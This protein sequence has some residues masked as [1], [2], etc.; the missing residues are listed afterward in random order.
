MEKLFISI[1]NRTLLLGCV[2]L[3]ASAVTIAIVAGV[4]FLNGRNPDI[5]KGYVNVAYV[6]L[7]PLTPGEA[8][9]GTAEDLTDRPSQEDI[10]LRAQATPG[11]QALGRVATTITNKRLDIRGS[12][13]TACEKTLAETAKE[14]D[15]KAAN[16]LSE[17]AGYFNQLANDPHLATRYPDAGG[18][19]QARQILEGLSRDFESKFQAQVNAQDA[20]NTAA[21]AE[22][23]EERLA[24]MTFLT[25]A[26]IAFLGFLCIAFL[27]VFL[28]I[29]KH[30]EK[31]SENGMPHGA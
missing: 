11:C 1:L 28:R 3:L 12:G 17:A 9:P 8:A 5:D 29:E 25:V 24:G 27:I 7:T 30:L 21:I 6:P 20:K 18:D 4:N 15:A 2:L 10:K 31:V 14:F 16:Y 13:L 23:S 22:A 26:G 19:D